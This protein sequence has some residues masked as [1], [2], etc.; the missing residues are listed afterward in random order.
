MA[1]GVQHQIN[2][3]LGE[4][5]AEGVYANLAIINHTPAEFV[6]DFVRYFP[7][8]PK[9]KVQT[10]II[11]TPQHIKS[12]SRALQDNIQKYEAA[13][14]EIK[15]IGDQKGKEFGFQPPTVESG[16]EKKS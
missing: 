13:Y 6:V 3:E 2:I 12:L 16:G 10:R 5:E 14:G 7:G 15:I 1:N 4:K 9:A 11:M 8:L